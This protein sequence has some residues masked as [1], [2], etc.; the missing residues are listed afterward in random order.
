MVA[1][2][3]S[4]T[5]NVL[6]NGFIKIEVAQEMTGPWFQLPYVFYEETTGD[7]GYIYDSWYSYGEG[8]V[9]IDWNCSFGRP[10][11]EWEEI[12]SLYEAYYK[13]TTIVE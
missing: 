10:L 2:N 3:P 11:A 4:V 5:Q 9:R 7:V 6:Q 1:T 12:S 13:I 8:A